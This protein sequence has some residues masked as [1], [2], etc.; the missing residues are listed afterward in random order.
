MYPIYI[1]LE[2]SQGGARVLESANKWIWEL[3]SPISPGK[4][5]KIISQNLDWN[6]RARDTLY[7]AHTYDPAVDDVQYS[8]CFAEADKARAVSGD[9]GLVIELAAKRYGHIVLFLKAGV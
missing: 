6:Y 5:A 4:N 3:D 1:L 9:S 8:E 7:F 2:T